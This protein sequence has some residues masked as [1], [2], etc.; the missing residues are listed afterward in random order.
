MTTVAIIPARKGSKGAPNKNMREL[1]GKPLLYWTVK[2]ACEATGIDRVVI[3]TDYH[4]IRAAL[5]D[6]RKKVIEFSRRPEM[7]Q[8]HVQVDEVALFTLRQMQMQGINP[9]RIVTLQP[10][11]P[12]RTAEDIDRALMLRTG[13]C[14]VISGYLAEGYYWKQKIVGI[15]DTHE[16][17]ILPSNIDL[18]PIGHEPLIRGGRQERRDL[19]KLFKE[20]GAIYI[21]SRKKLEEHK[22]MRVPPFIPYIMSN[23]ASIDID[24]EEDWKLAKSMEGRLR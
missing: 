12:F 6:N 16:G 19:Q 7:A 14:T 21:T 24:T 22:V 18:V 23:E 9:D 15:P 20:N 3:T 17:I 10:T 2:A 13:N 8:D 11:S 1:A 4:D 5:P